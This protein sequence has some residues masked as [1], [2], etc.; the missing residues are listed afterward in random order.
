MNNFYKISVLI[1]LS[2]LSGCSPEFRQR[3]ADNIEEEHNPN[4]KYKEGRRLE[5][6]AY[7][8][9]KDYTCNELKNLYREVAYSFNNEDRVVRRA[10]SNLAKQK[11]CSGFSEDINRTYREDYL[12]SGRYKGGIYK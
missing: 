5:R 8:K 4:A 7:E 2:I 9:Y 11:H 6:K 3:L 10:L 12:K 1:L